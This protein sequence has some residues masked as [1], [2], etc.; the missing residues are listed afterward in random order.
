MIKQTEQIQRYKAIEKVI[1]DNQDL[2]DKINQLKTVQKQ[3]VNAK[4]IQ[5]KSDHPFPRDLR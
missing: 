2:K 5:K 1:N 4:E 3:L